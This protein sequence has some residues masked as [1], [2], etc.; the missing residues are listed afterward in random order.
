MFLLCTYAAKEATRKTKKAKLCK[1]TLSILGCFTADMSDAL[2]KKCQVSLYS[3]N[4]SQLSAQSMGSY[5][6]SHYS[7]E[8]K[9][10][11]TVCA[12]E[13]A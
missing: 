9:S 7:I 13:R 5:G 3:G 10:L 8:I 11:S 12:T 4:P 2:K 1:W 6:N